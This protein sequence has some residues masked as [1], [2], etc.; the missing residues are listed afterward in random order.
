[1][2]APL[3][4]LPVFSPVAPDKRGRCQQPQGRLHTLPPAAAGQLLSRNGGKGGGGGGRGGAGLPSAPELPR[5]PRLR[6]E[7]ALP[8]PRRG[9]PAGPPLGSLPRR[10]Q[11]THRSA[12]RR[13]RGSLWPRSWPPPGAVF[14]G[15]GAAWPRG[16]GAAAAGPGLGGGRCWTAGVWA[17]AA[18]GGTRLGRSSSKCGASHSLTP[19]SLRR[20]AAAAAGALPDLAAHSLPR[21]LLLLRVRARRPRPSGQSAPTTAAP[22]AFSSPC[23]LS[24]PRP[25]CIW[26]EQ[27]P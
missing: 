19:A 1:M 7:G 25:Q 11:T 6:E 23:P 27:T 10:K 2:G 20:R 22:R 12:E 8:G 26:L 18:S 24:P 17:A 13:R 9:P 3:A 4:R 16:C 14:A 21:P 5:T 15:L